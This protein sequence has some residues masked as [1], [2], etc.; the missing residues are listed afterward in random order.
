LLIA[1]GSRLSLLPATQHA[2]QFPLRLLTPYVVAFEFC[3]LLFAL[4]TVLLPKF[5]RSPLVEAEDPLLIAFRWIVR[6]VALALSF[7]ALGVLVFL[8]ILLFRRDSTTLS[9]LQIENPW[10]LAGVWSVA[11]AA[12]LVSRWFLVEFIG[13]VAAYVSAHRLS[14]FNELRQAIQKCVLDVMGGVYAARSPR[15]Y[16]YEKIIVAGHS[17]G[18][19]IS[20]DLL[21]QLLVEDILAAS[22]TDARGRVSQDIQKRTK[23]LLTFGSPLDKIAYLFRIKKSTDELR[24]AG[25]AAWQPL[26]QN[27]RFRPKAWLNIYSWMDLFSAPLHFYDN[28][29]VP[30]EPK[31]IDNRIDWRAWVPIVA[32]TAYWTDPILGDRLYDTIVG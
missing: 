30:Q 3:L 29:D 23:L 13:D 26:I 12:A 18:S 5:Y 8:E 7:G 4:G 16:Q 27:Y 6:I 2:T 31:H 25:A 17:L 11:V 15:G 21:N 24:E 9:F 14:K 20:Y 1:V 28:P 32:H 10:A 19:V 22:A